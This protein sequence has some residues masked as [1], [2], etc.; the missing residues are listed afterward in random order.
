MNRNIN[1]SNKPTLF[2]FDNAW[3][4]PKLPPQ[5]YQTSVLSASIAFLETERSHSVPN[6]GSTVGGG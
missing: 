1:Q 3:L 4:V 6:Q 5:C 2:F